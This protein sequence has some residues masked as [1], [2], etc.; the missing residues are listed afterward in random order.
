MTE[1]KEEKK[2]IS[3]VEQH[4]ENKLEDR[5]IPI[6]RPSLFTPMKLVRFPSLFGDEKKERSS[7]FK[8]ENVIKVNY[9]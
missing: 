8:E 4:P 9:V 2:D 6:D 3:S 1:I 5:P 7:F